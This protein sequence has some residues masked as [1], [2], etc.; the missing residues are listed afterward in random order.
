MPTT[1]P[2][3]LAILL[4]RESPR[5]LLFRRGPTTRVELV[6]WNTKTDRFEFGQ[7]FTGRIYEHRC[8]LSPDGHFLVYFASKFNAHTVT[9]SD[10]TY[11]WTA[12][13]RPPYLTAL[14][15]WPKGNCWWG[16]GLF[17]DNS[18]LLLNHRPQEAVPHPAHLPT[19]IRVVPNE[20]A[21]G[22]DDPL[23][24]DRLERDGWR[25]Q[26]KWKTEWLDMERG[27]ETVSPEIRERQHPD[28][29]F[30]ISLTRRLDNLR[31]SEHFDVLG[32]AGDVKIALAKP[33]WLDWDHR[34]RL[35][36]LARG[37]LWV[38]NVRKSGIGEFS[39]LLDLTKHR[40]EARPSPDWAKE[41]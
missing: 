15:L 31:Y 17:Q 30:R 13:S 24:S 8:D 36:A 22:E 7:W 40:Y 11:A 6:L 3:R 34:G 27:Y 29:W 21:A 10:Y 26:Q 39:R 2:P 12:V 1:P 25:L 32:P 28:G 18:T 9:D 33:S 20:E 5:A 14:A 19:R 37:G 16:G 4:A 23:Y 38:A 35:V 41:W